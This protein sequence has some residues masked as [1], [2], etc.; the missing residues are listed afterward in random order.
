MQRRDFI[1][2]V[3]GVSCAGLFGGC[4]MFRPDDL[5]YRFGGELH[6]DFHASIL[7]GYNY[8]KDTY[9]E[10]AIRE[11]M[12]Q[13]A[14][15]VH[16]SMHEKLAAGDP[17]EL[18]EFW[19]YYLG[20]EGGDFSVEEDDAG[21]TLTVRRCP[22]LAY[23]EKRQVAGGEGLCA[24]TRLFNEELAKG[25]PFTAETRCDGGTCRQVFRRTP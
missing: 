15:A 4:A 8:V 1:K 17:S 20:R 3:G 14:R 25:T 9:G 5:R 18:L 21:V 22:A 13:F 10:A 12:G 7:D 24:A 6:K 19:R 2:G 11:V 16:R 23:L